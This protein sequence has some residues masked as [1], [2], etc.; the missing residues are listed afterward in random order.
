MAQP[1][2][3]IMFLFIIDQ[4]PS[5]DVVIID[6]FLFILFFIRPISLLTIINKYSPLLPG[7]KKKQT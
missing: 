1:S 7:K 2:R 5:T 3:S 6:S 4:S